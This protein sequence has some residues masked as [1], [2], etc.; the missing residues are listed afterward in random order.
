MSRS[1]TSLLLA[2]GDVRGGYPTPEKVFF[3]GYGSLSDPIIDFLPTELPNATYTMA[4]TV[5][6]AHDC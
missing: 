6:L 5:I 2:L 1:E 3:L 4:F